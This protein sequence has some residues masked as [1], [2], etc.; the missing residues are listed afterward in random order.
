MTKFASAFLFLLLTTAGIAQT[1]EITIN[2][3][4]IDNSC[5]SVRT[6]QGNMDTIRGKFVG[7]YH[8]EITGDCL[9]LGIMYG[10]CK[11]EMEFVTDNNV[12]SSQSYRM[13]FLLKYFTDVTNPCKD[14]Y[15]TKVSFDLTPFKNM[16][17][18]NVIFI[19]LMGTTFNLPYRQLGQ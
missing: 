9:E 11:P 15:K 12:L 10:G 3:V 1:P 18:G 19:S 8:A 2:S 17:P 13:R 7:I 5:M 16:R 4:P 14:T 6:L